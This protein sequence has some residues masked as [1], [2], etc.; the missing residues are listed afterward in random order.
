MTKLWMYNTFTM[1]R[2]IKLVAEEVKT[3]LFLRKL[4]GQ[5]CVDFT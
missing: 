2:T 4:C 5:S 1:Q 3:V